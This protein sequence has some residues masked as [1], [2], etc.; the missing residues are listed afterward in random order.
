MRFKSLFH[1]AAAALVLTAC[2]AAASAQVTTITGKVTL[3]QADGTDAPLAGAQVDIYRTDITQKFQAKTDK[4]GVYTHAGIPFAGTYTLVVSAPGARPTWASKIRFNQ[5]PSRD[6]TLAPGDGSTL[7]LE[8]IK[9]LEAAGGGS[10]S[11]PA[12]MSADEKARREEMAKKVAEVEESNKKIIAGNEAVGAAFKA[13]NEALNAKRYDE[14]ITHYNQGL[15]VRGE[16]A[17]YAN[18]SVALRLRGAERFNAV[19]QS[20]DQAAKT[21]GLEAARKDWVEAADAGKKAVEMMTAMEVPAD[22]TAKANYERNKVAAVASHAEAMKLVATKVDQSRAEE[23]Y[24]LY[25]DYA[26]Q[27]VDP[28]KKAKLQADAVKILFDAGA[29]PRAAEEYQKVVAADPENATAYLYLGFSLFNTGD[30]AKFQEAA[31]YI[32]RFVEKAPETDPMKGEAKSILEFLKAN[33]NIKPEKI[34]PVRTTG[35]RRG[36]N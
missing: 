34:Q 4:R 10:S 32:G 19:I 27:E 25:A 15:A 18:K 14:A 26:A 16:A 20:Q 11:A 22:P 36:T 35:R 6:F 2:A 17:L 5:A 9:E 29:Y 12:E 24:K 8:R 30:K 13:G 31:N 33:E 3:R 21:A 23:A 7:T 1:A 28:A